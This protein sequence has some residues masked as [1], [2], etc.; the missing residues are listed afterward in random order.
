MKIPEVVI[1]GIGD[2]AQIAAFYFER[3]Q[4][5]KVRA[6]TVDSSHLGN[7]TE[8]NGVPIVAFEKVVE[9]FPPNSHKMF[10]AVSYSEM[11]RFRARKFAEAKQKGYELISYVSPEA[12]FRSQYEVGENTF[13][14]ED[15]TVQPFV[16]IGS[17]VT[18]WS[19][20]HIG[21]HSEVEDHNFVS[22]HVVIS[23]HCL[24][25]SFCFLGVNSTVGH[26]VT[27][28]QGTLL[29]A[30]AVVTKNTEENGVYV[31]PRTVKLGVA[32]HQVAL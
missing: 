28:A 5:A 23:G 4:V 13:V 31:P 16:R 1:F 20:N 24:V 8:L 30:G 26:G 7:L 14:F 10:V 15:N 21:H 3:D 32:S 27:L 6:F 18:L 11:N 19:G 2:V 22:S 9:L 29:G 25:S 12:T 17:N